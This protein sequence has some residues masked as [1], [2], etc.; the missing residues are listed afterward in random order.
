[1][2][3]DDDMR[4][5]HLAQMLAHGQPRLPSTDDKRVYLFS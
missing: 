5:T 1:M 3:F 2:P 4:H